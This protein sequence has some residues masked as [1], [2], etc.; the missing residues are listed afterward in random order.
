MKR[1]KQLLYTAGCLL[2]FTT[3]TSCVEEYEVDLGNTE[4]CLVV[5]GTIQSDTTC[6]FTLSHSKGLNDGSIGY[7]NDAVLYITGSDGSRWEGKLQMNQGS[8]GGWSSSWGTP[9]WGSY[10]HSGKYSVTTGTLYPDVEYSLEII[11][12]GDHYA[13]IPQ[14][15]L[16]SSAASVGFKQDYD[17]ECINILLSVTPQS[18]EKNEY[19]LWDYEELWEIQSEFSCRAVYSRDADAILTYDNAPYDQGWRT[20]KANTILLGSAEDYIN[21]SLTDKQLISFSSADKR[22]S[23]YY[24]VLVTQRNI[25]KGEYEYY[26]CRMQQDYEMDGLFTPQPTELPTNIRCTSNKEKQIIG[27][28][29]CNR[30]VVQQRL[31]ISNEEVLYTY[32]ANCR[33]P[34]SDLE[35]ASPRVL[36]DNGF[37]LATYNPGSSTWVTKA[38]VDVREWGA[39]TNTT[40]RP[41]WWPIPLRP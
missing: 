8:S 38:C 23:V 28:V 6:L 25:S 14:K 5:E 16:I 26:K 2:T 1:M 31:N 15:P 40:L 3:V 39:S 12:Q 13:S 41:S 18:E 27:Y 21:G 19:Y 10:A 24:S 33:F 9:G 20:N 29:G 30:N 7:I 4:P 37:Q 35:N 17:K 34:S 36:F 32:Q 11:W 22:I